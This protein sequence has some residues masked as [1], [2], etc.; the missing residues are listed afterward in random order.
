MRRPHPSAP[1]VP[2]PEASRPNGAPPPTGSGR[3]DAGKLPP[4]RQAQHS[5]PELLP[6]APAAVRAAADQVLAAHAARGAQLSTSSGPFVPSRS[7]QLDEPSD[8]HMIAL[9]KGSVVGGRY[10][11]EFMIGRGGMGTVYGVRHVNTDEK[12]AL[13]LLHPALAENQAAVERFRTEARAPVR[14]E[15][16][17]V[18]RVVDA[19]IASEIGV[20]YIVM[21]RLRGH[22][23]RSEL[24]RRGALPAGEV[25]LY[26]KQAARALDKA[27][28]QGIVH[29]DLKP[30]NMYVLKREDGSPLLKVLDFGIAKLTDDA[31]KE[32][33]VAGQ[34][35][36]TP[37]YMAP[38]QARGDL[39]RV[40][41]G[42]DLW[43]LGLITYQLLTGRNYW[44]ADGMAA[45]VG[46][47]CYEPMPPPTQSAPHLGP[48]FDMWFARACHRDPNQRFTSGQAMI[49]ELSHA[50]GVNQSGGI[51][52]GSG[53]YA[54]A[55]SSLQLSVPAKAHPHGVSG[56][57]SFPSAPALSTPGLGAPL[58]AGTTIPPST[59][60][61]PHAPVHI[62]EATAAPLYSTTSP[63]TKSGAATA[64]ALGVVIALVIGG[65]GLGVWMVMPHESATAAE[66]SGT[67]APTVTPAAPT[68]PTDEPEP[69]VAPDPTE[70]VAAPT[71][72]ASVSA[73]AAPSAEASAAPEPK[74]PGPSGPLPAP[75]GNVRPQPKEQPSTVPKAAPKVGEIDF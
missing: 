63:K 75:H 12:L 60:P 49:D 11:I 34:V 32:L 27:H 18:V 42:T 21:E 72:S 62:M 45:L 51:T 55:D 20:P 48:L 25:V 7:K 15:S 19:D 46:Q 2:P 35:F 37:W 23:L 71:A 29:R 74:I 4:P 14:I 67:T 64:V 33:T 26:M 61:Q 53:H 10:L 24:K 43:A 50:L 13:K 52:T 56:P 65:A 9:R 68:D 40:G 41:P 70:E 39:A 1:A 59:T 8:V 36:G 57:P 44:T 16:E 17:H 54:N 28:K 73:S 69:E 31:A 6:G 22:D 30:A 38:E 58:A 3:P 66:T 5:A 47:I